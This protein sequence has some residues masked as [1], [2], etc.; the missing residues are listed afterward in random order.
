MPDKTQR[1]IVLQLL[2]DDHDLQWTQQE[3]R[4]E[5][6]TDDLDAALELLRSE[7]CVVL[8]GEQVRASTSVCRLD[9][10]ELLAI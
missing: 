7:G 9:E 2:R 8:D 4:D 3:L 10:L 1:A 6:G 5:I